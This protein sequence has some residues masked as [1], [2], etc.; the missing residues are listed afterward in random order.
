MEKVKKFKEFGIQPESKG[1]VGDKIDVD[2]IINTEIVVHDYRIETS[3]YPGKGNS[4]CLHMQ[5]SIGDQK[6]VV[7]TGSTVLQYEIQ[8]ISKSDFPFETT[9]VRD[10]KRLEFT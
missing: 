6:R 8:K 10:N 5:I 1:F 2:R 3:K 9:I 7:F 4:K